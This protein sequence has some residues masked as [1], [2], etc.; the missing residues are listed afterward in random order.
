VDLTDHICTFHCE[1]CAT[2]AENARYL[3]LSDDEAQA[4]MDAWLLDQDRLWVAALANRPR[5]TPSRFRPAR[6]A[7]I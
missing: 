3:A 4:E 1:S 6:H 7:A 5:R 2:A